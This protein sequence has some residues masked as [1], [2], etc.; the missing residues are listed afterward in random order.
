MN[1]KVFVDTNI[2]LYAYDKDA[3]EK[4]HRAKAAIQNVWETQ[5]GVLSTQVLEEFYVNV[6]R[7]IPRPL[8]RAEAR[9]VIGQYVVWEIVTIDGPMV[10]EASRVEERSRLS[11]WDAL[12]V[13]SAQKGGATLLLSEDFFHGQQLGGL[14][15]QN[16]FRAA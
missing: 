5:E 12:I 14:V 13:V 1:D 16:P 3:G 10:L 4:H 9:E 11:F 2:L 15:I 6:T 8:S 7:K